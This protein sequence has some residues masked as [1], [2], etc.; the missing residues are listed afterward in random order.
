MFVANHR[1]SHELEIKVQ[2]PKFSQEHIQSIATFFEGV[3]NLSS[4]DEAMSE[5]ES[6]EKVVPENQLPLNTEIEALDSLSQELRA[7]VESLAQE[8]CQEFLERH[9]DRLTHEL[10][11]FWRAH[12]SRIFQQKI[13]MYGFSS[14]EKAVARSLPMNLQSVGKDYYAH[15]VKDFFSQMSGFEVLSIGPNE[16]YPKQWKRGLNLLLS[17]APEES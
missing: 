13:F 14:A 7:H 9:F 3:L 1:P 12:P 5:K 11:D 4:L 16:N 8:S 2:L 6:T 17:I 15:L 10:T